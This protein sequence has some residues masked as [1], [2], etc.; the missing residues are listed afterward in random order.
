MREIIRMLGLCLWVYEF[1]IH[2]V[3]RELLKS[4]CKIKFENIYSRMGNTCKPWAVSFQCMTKSTTNK[5]KKKKEKKISVVK[6][7]CILWLQLCK[8]IMMWAKPERQS[9]NSNAL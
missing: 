9:T 3:L 4:Q 5:K 1:S 6:I 2:M 8:K 7:I